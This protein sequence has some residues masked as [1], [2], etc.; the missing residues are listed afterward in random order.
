MTDRVCKGLLVVAAVFTLIIM[1]GI[2]ATSTANQYKAEIYNQISE[3]LDGYVD[4]S[5]D[6]VNLVKQEIEA[7]ELDSLGLSNDNIV[8]SMLNKFDYKILNI[9]KKDN[10]ATAT[11]LV[12]SKK[13]SD[14]KDNISDGIVRLTSDPSLLATMSVEEVTQKYNDTVMKAFEMLPLT[15]EEVTFEYNKTSDGWTLTEESTQKMNN[16]LVR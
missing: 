14:L 16:I 10:K 4:E 5:P 13:I 8:E 7:L 1:V 6:S 9:S 2:V 12:V 15:S 3:T 11:V